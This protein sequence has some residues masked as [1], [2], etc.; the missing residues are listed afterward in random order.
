MANK[1]HPQHYFEYGF[2]IVSNLCELMYGTWNIEKNMRT[3]AKITDNG[4]Q[5]TNHF[6]VFFTLLLSLSMTVRDRPQLF[7]C[8]CEM[9]TI[10]NFLRRWSSSL[11]VLSSIFSPCLLFSVLLSL[12]VVVPPRCCL[13]SSSS[14]CVVVSLH[15]LSASLSSWVDFVSPSGC[16]LCVHPQRWLCIICFFVHRLS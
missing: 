1:A 8:I 14:L 15:C 6:F 16:W 4:L 10:Q 11:C 2:Q 3:V 12:I 7:I 9:Q 13:S 5:S